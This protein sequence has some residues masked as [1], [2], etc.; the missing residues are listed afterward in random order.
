MA[1]FQ[2]MSAPIL[3]RGAEDA[4]VQ[5]GRREGLAPAG[6]MTLPGG[7][8]LVC[9]LALVRR[10]VRPKGRG[11]EDRSESVIGRLRSSPKRKLLWNV[12]LFPYQ[13]ELHFPPWYFIG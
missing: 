10:A 4:R 2:S 3:V 6:A 9:V 8:V 11:L 12:A 7:S 13:S 1:S 5:P